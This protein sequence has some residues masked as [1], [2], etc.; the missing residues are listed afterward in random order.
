M[1]SAVTISIVPEAAAGPFVFH[2]NIAA[3]C[4]AAREIGFEAIE[5]FAGGPDQVPAKQLTQLL[6]DNGLSLAAVGTGAGWLQQKLSLT[7]AEPSTRR[8]AIDF[9]RSMI[10][11]GA[12]NDAPAIIGSMQ[13]RHGDGVPQK[14]ANVY[15]ADA[16]R[17]L[18]SHAAGLNTVLLY[19]PL[20]RYETNLFNR[21][22]HTVAFVKLHE[23][24]GVKL[25]ADLFHMNIEEANLAD[26]IRECGPMLEHVHLADS[27]RRPAGFGHTDFR[28]IGEALREIGYNGAISAEA[29]PYPDSVEAAKATMKVFQ[30]CFK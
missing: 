18:G 10:D 8:K 26:S 21:L 28:P 14:M 16:L 30:A 12:E 1:R 19:E 2:D 3:A 13:G 20:N 6:T 9:I 5:L 23:I 24:V 17:E 29:F 22:S 11:Y 15:L 7:A 4:R 27:N 25:L